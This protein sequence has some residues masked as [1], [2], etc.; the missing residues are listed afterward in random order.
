PLA[1]LADAVLSGIGLSG[2]DPNK[3]SAPYTFGGTAM[4]SYFDDTSMLRR[5][6][7]EMAVAFSGPRA[8][9]MQA[10]H[11]VA[12][13]GFFAHSGALDEPYERLRRTAEV[14]DTVAFGSK[15]DADR[16][17][18]RVRS[19]H[20][21]VRGELEQPAGRFPARTQLPARDPHL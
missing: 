2:H 5:I 10:A 15:R 14:M 21:K 16:A 18:R 12:F 19:M 11:P 17:T 9:L 3:G 1:Q 4:D 8:L 20:G 6:H 13:E 7:R